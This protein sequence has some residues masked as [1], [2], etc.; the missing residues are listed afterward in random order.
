MRDGLPDVN[1]HD[2]FEDHRGRLWAATRAHGFFLFTAD[3]SHAAPV[4]VRTYA[5]R[6]GLATMWV[7]QLFETSDHRFWV[8][9][10]RGVAEFFPE[11]GERERKFKI[12]T[13]RSGL[14]Y[15]GVNM[16]NE[17]AGGNLWLG[18]D[19]GAMKLARDGFISYGEQD[20]LLS[21]FATFGDRA[22]RVCFRAAIFG[23]EHGSVFEGAKSDLWHPLTNFH[24]RYGRFDG[25][26]FT[27]LKPNLIKETQLG[28]VG[29]MVTL[30][31]RNGEWWLGTGQGVYRFPASDNFAT[32]K[33]ARPLAVYTIK[34][35]LTAS[36][37]FRLFEDSRGGI[38]A[39]AILPNGFARWDRDGGTWHDFSNAPG[40]PSPKDDL[41]RS[42]GEDRDGNVWVGF[43][44]GAARYGDGGFTFFNT[45][46]GLPPGSV[47]NFHTDRQGRLWIT[48]ARSG[49]I[50]V[51]DPGAQRPVFINYT[52]AQGL[53]SNSTETVVEDLNGYIYVSTGRGPDR[54]D[55]ATGHVKH[56]TTAEGLAPG[57][58]LAA[59][60]DAT[61]TLWFGTAKGLSRFVPRTD[62]RPVAPPPILITGLSV[63]SEQQTI[64]A[65]GE[66]EVIL[67]N[68]AAD[69]N[70]LQINFV[71]LSFAPGEVLRYQY[72]LEGSDADWSAQWRRRTRR[73][74]LFHCSHL[75]RVRRGH[76]RYRVGHQSTA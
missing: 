48:S 40:L 72:R 74:T 8:A 22:G 14:L 65:L 21:V 67:P 27:W 42:F 19:A 56:Y 44:T 41:A 30:Q 29:E 11:A 68:L 7:A 16:V 51:D 59:F 66:T 58:V 4:V 32:L 6:D 12:Y 76:G 43:N 35:G 10:N 50:R 26:S 53:S 61:G 52:T 17:D 2:L 33:R 24:T 3:D 75:A 20:G 39:S 37:V 49:L 5:E 46:D 25:R 63:A 38:W 45:T 64:S 55:P 54:L 62:A 73:A 70:Q 60:R 9:T 18:S 47:M 71:G 36:Q 31:A 23:D 1:L 28:W 15:Y 69:R 34:E 57:R 13:Q